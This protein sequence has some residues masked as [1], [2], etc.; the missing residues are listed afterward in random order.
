MRGLVETIYF[1]NTSGISEFLA[2]DMDDGS[3]VRMRG[4]LLRPIIGAKLCFEMRSGRHLKKNGGEDYRRMRHQCPGIFKDAGPCK[5]ITIRARPWSVK[6]RRA[7]H[8]FKDSG[9]PQ[10]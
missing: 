8:V 7:D 2:G 9:R 4:F 1:T 3:R 6:D 10:R 5:K